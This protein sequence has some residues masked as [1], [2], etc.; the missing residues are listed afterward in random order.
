MIL[1][2]NSNIFSDLFPIY[3][4]FQLSKLILK[5]YFHMQNIILNS[6]F[7]FRQ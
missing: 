6:Y 7:L 2:K 5:I 4:N 3:F 1:V